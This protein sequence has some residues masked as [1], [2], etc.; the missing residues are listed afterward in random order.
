MNLGWS[1]VRVGLEGV[2]TGETVVGMYG[3]REDYSQKLN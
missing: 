1:G 3:R 2:K